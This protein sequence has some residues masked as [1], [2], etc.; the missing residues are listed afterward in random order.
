MIKIQ[1]SMKVMS[2]INCMSMIIPIK[3]HETPK[4]DGISLKINIMKDRKVT[5]TKMKT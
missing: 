4:Q 5:S 2:F 3:L 1:P